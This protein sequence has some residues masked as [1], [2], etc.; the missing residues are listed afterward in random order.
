MIR[1]LI[2]AGSLVL[3]FSA[4]G[5]APACDTPLTEEALKQLVSGGVPAARIRQLISSCGIDIG[6]SNTAATESRLKQ[7]GVASSVFSAL[8]PPANPPKGA[9][10]TSPF[11]R[12]AMVAVP[13]GAFRMGSD[14]AEA[15]R[16]ADEDAHDVKVGAFWVDVDEVTNEAYRRF[17]ISRPEWQKGFISPAF[18]DGNY[19]KDWTG[20]NFPAGRGNMPVAW[21][22]WHAARAYAAWA[23]KRLPTEVEW[24]YAARAGSTTRFWWGADFDASRVITDPSAPP[25]Q[26][27]RANAWGIRDTTGSV[28]EWTATLFRPYPYSVAEAK[29]DVNARGPRAT[30]GGSRANGQN[31]LRVANRS[32]EEPIVTSDLIGFRCAR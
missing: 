4:V 25:P 30:R 27:Q 2:F 29:E 17:V 12:R 26:E 19:L 15:N 11:D 28:W 13:A 31:F 32:M 9:T 6:Q 14:A 7:I 16:D 23:G 10:W 3:S 5:Q 21:V 20:S 24:E 18:H 1:A 22:S 8:A